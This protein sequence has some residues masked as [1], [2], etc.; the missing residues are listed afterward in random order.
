[1]KAQSTAIPTPDFQDLFESA[2]GLYLVLTTELVIVAASNA[3]LVA[4]MT[5]REEILGRHLFDV[6]PDNPDDPTA[7][8][9]RNLKASLDSVLT[10]SAPDA[11][12]V[13]K[14][15]IRRP[16]S[17]G[18]G[19]VERYW[20]SV[21]S[22]VFDS[23]GA[24]A[25]IIHRVEDVTEFIRLKKQEHAQVKE[26]KTLRIRMEQMESEIYLRSQQL[27]EVNRKLQEVNRETSGLLGAIV[28][29][30]EDA[31]I[32]ETFESIIS[33]WNAA[34]ERLYGYN[35]AEAIGQHI[36]LIIPDERQPE[37][38]HIIAQIRKGN[39]IEHFETVRMHKDG[40]RIDVSLT[41]S[42]IH[43]ATGQ[44]IGASKIARD[45]TEDKAIQAQLKLTLQEV[46]IAKR[47]A[48]EAQKKA[49]V[50]NHT[51]DEFLANMSHEIRTPLNSMIGL[52]ELLLETELTTQQESNIRTVLASAETLIEIINDL[53]DFSKIEAGKLELSTIRFDLRVAIEDTVELFA[54]K[55]REKDDH[56]ELLVHFMPDAP[57]YVMGDPLRLRQILS[58]LLSN[59]IK[60]TQQGYIL[61]TIAKGPA[62]TSDDKVAI[63]IDI[64]DSGIGIAADKLQII[65]DK[66]SQ[67][68]IST[69]RKFGGTGLG[70][71]ICRQLAKMMQGDV[72]A[73]STPGEGSTFSVNLLLGRD[74]QP[75]VDNSAYT[76]RQLLKGKCAL[77]VDDFEPGRMVLTVQLTGAGIR[78]AATKDAKSAVIMLAKAQAKG[79]PFDMLVTDYMLPEMTSEPFTQFVKREYPDIAVVM[80]TALAEKGYAQLFAS[81]G[82][83]AYLTKPMRAEQLLDMLSM[84]FAAK[85]SGKQLS[86]LTPLTLFRK[87]SI[88][89]NASDDNGFLEGAEILL[90][91]DNRANRELVVRILEN[92]G[93]NPTTARNGEEAIEVTEKRSFDLILMD[94][95]MPEMDGF[96]ASQILDKMKKQEKIP[97]MPIIALTAN[98]MKGDRERC[99]ESGM[100]DYISKPLRKTA[101]RSILMQWLPAKEKRVARQ[102]HSYHL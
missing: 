43:D 58:N 31:I 42:P 89:R 92:F 96:E 75:P 33:S 26:N 30:S 80:V 99:L 60:F 90:V 51:K 29:S 40:K 13:H 5:R 44:I 85:Q 97:D 20:S 37:E 63:Q 36:R 66:F 4:T 56:V 101:L 67:A 65:F 82:C 28:E 73:K 81:A 32:S 14:Y 21:N 86:M 1:M 69:T 70:L 88:P 83:D 93:C 8:P 61:I 10:Y 35:A 48:E 38:K 91:E 98:A 74:P 64:R 18:G 72:T 53:L 2:P 71:A 25:Y 57:R 9:T 54:P 95:Q 34:A 50:A 7:H 55:A 84:I 39:R 17:E 77:I 79:E 76:D 100:N 49:E 59:A 12:A 27:A 22:P 6:F 3:Y 102:L 94:C 16:K 62:Q 11:M 19:F 24:I 87:G 41:V 45:V 46:I 15:D 68:D 78:C 23:D 47:S 52:T